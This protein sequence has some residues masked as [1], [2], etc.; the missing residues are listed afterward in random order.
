[1]PPQSRQRVD[2]RALLPALTAE[3]PQILSDLLGLLREDLPEYAAFLEEDPDDLLQIAEQA[4]H[5]LVAI[6]ELVPKQ[7]L[8]MPTETSAATAMFEELGRAE[9][10]EGRTLGPLLAAYRSGARVAWRHISRAAMDR[11]LDPVDLSALA[12]AIFVFVD[13][14][15]SASVR[16]FLDEQHA[17]TAARQQLRA[18]LSELLVSDRS[19]TNVVRATALRAGWSM[20]TTAAL[21]LIDPADDVGT[22]IARLDSQCL[23]MRY[24]GLSGAIVPDPD[25]PGRRAQMAL[26]LRGARAVV[27]P[28][29][30]LAQLPASISVAAA[31]MRLLDA[32]VIADDPLFIA[33]HLDSVIVLGDLWIR[34]QLRADVLAPLAGLPAT[35]RLRLEE[36]LGAWLRSMGNRLEAAAMLQVHPQTV[37]YR[38]RQLQD[39]YGERWEDPDLRLKL[40]LAVCW[41]T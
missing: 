28:V 32:G 33:E 9:W 19:D 1:M 26:S 27:G 41:P 21:V 5:Y 15:S 34:D 13:E 18:E 24:G 40:T 11:D 10:R 6:A 2:L 7:R 22:L 38:L 25:A 29:V 12:E 31:G 35:T 20:P 14:L 17:T 30:P 4:V 37:R 36:T 39:L 23:P 8:G 3:L 16:G